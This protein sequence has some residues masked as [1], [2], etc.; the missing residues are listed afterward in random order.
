MLSMPNPAI[1]VGVLL[2]EQDIF[3]VQSLVEL[4]LVN[5]PALDS[6]VATYAAKVKD[7]DARKTFTK[8]A[9]SYLANSEK[10][11]REA[12]IADLDEKP[13]P[14]WVIKCREQ[15]QRIDFFQPDDDTPEIL[16]LVVEYLN[17][18]PE[19][20]RTRYAF[21][22]ILDKAL[23][24]HLHPAANVQRDFHGV[25][26]HK[27]RDGAV[28]YT[29]APVPNWDELRAERDARR[30]ERI[31]A[32]RHAGQRVN[33]DGRACTVNLVVKNRQIVDMN[34]YVLNP[35]NSSELRDAL[36]FVI[37]HEHLDIS[38]YMPPVAKLSGGHTAV[39][40]L[41][42]GARD[43]VSI[44]LKNCIGLGSYDTGCTTYAILTPNGEPLIAICVRAGR[45]DE[46]KGMSNVELRGAVNDPRHAL[47][48][49]FEAT[50]GVLF[51]VVDC[52][53][54]YQR[55]VDDLQPKD[56]VSGVLNLTG[57]PI[58]DLPDHL[59]VRGNL[60]LNGSGLN[61]LPSDLKVSGILDIRNTKIR[62]IPEDLQAND[63]RADRETVDY[64]S[65]C[66][67]LARSSSEVVRK[68]YVEQHCNTHHRELS[69]EER[70]AKFDAEVMPGLLQRISEVNLDAPCPPEPKPG[71]PGNG[72]YGY[73]KR[74]HQIFSL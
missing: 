56:I 51:G 27:Q 71:R 24:H 21:K 66:R 69:M 12:M 1:F 47:L 63:L 31:D 65:V 39:A 64:G 53:G 62:D 54:G 5:R 19:E 42:N 61:E 60:M 73:W 8:Q 4:N 45:I 41:S 55:R 7:P 38:T 18:N 29:L 17:D 37:E 32:R 16:D 22:V 58:T 35:G 15:G 74:L 11:S 50:P 13:V 25:T 48:K 40:L 28:V 68:K 46:A 23:E 3:E 10:D 67:W 2:E 34:G 49:E 43:F 30:A 70:S 59:E 72:A 20:A 52:V 9:T 6:F 44:M 33:D 26:K 14:E 36:R 57:N